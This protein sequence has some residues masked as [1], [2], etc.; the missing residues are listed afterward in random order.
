MHR[1]WP[2][3][4]WLH[5]VTKW[6]CAIMITGCMQ[7]C[8]IVSLTYFKG[9]DSMQIFHGQLVKYDVAVT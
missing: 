5:A 4:L 2:N 6:H 8:V 9:S 1:P 3:I 7:S